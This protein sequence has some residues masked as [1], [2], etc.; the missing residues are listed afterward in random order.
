[1][2]RRKAVVA[3]QFYPGSADDLYRLIEDMV[4]PDLKKQTAVCAIS[5][6]AGFIYSGPVA[7]ALFSS[8][9]VPDHIIIL[10]PDHQG[11]ARH[12]SLIKKGAWETPLGDTLIDTELAQLI[13]Q[14]TEMIVDDYDAHAYEHSLE[15]Q[16]PF[17]QYF[18]PS[19]KL[20][21]IICPYFSALPDL[22][23]LGKRLAE[24]ISVFP[25]PVLLVASTDM[26][27]QESSDSAR[28]KDFMA[29]DKIETLDAAGLYQTVKKN[30][31]SMCGFQAV[32][33]A[34]A[35]SL[36]LGAKQAELIK[37]Q[38]SGD[39]TGDHSRVVG[40]AGIRISRPDS[41]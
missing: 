22:L 3:G 10:G 4:V 41:I 21:P 13:L 26:S 28:S 16:L 5:P 31:I 7:G 25:H 27:H 38:N 29:I 36:A 30:K 35:A 15:V 1:M 40:Y 17:I 6:H 23:V 8:V 9:T 34:L 18:N 24:T 37:Y 33:A 12:F 14:S 20:V 19:S 39:I 11:A 32:T 2:K